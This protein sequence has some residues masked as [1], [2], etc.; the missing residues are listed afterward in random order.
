MGR[1]VLLRHLIIRRGALVGVADEDGDRRT[2]R[3]ALVE[4]GEDLRVIRL[5]A[6]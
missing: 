4:A 2:E 5:L 1:P 3:P 6:W